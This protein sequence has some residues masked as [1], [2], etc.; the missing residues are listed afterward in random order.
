M[1]ARARRAADDLRGEGI[2]V[3]FMRSIFVPE[4]GACFYLYKAASADDVYA[5]ARRARLQCDDIAVA[6]TEHQEES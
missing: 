1:V 6:I 4:D 5:S 3:H 2:E